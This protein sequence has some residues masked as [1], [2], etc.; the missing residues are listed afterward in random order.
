MVATFESEYPEAAAFLQSMYRKHGRLGE[1]IHIPFI[2][3]AVY[4]GQPSVSRHAS[5]ADRNKPC[6][7]GSGK[8]YKKCCL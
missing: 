3:Q 6:P 7:C 5:G 8:K 2:A 1:K 4:Y